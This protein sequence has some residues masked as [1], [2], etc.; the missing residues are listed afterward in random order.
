MARTRPPSS[1]AS[2]RCR[3]PLAAPSHR[4]TR[5]LLSP[6]RGCSALPSRTGSRRLLPRGGKSLAQFCDE[7]FFHFPGFGLQHRLTD[8]AETPGEIRLN[9]VNDFGAGAVIF[10]ARG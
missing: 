7:V 10:E 2:G 1:S 5:A 4:W 6:R 8:A 3:P 9:V